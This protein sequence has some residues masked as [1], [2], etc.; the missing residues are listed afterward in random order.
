MPVINRL[1]DFKDEFAALRRELHQNPQ[2]KYEETFAAETIAKTL[3]ALGI[4]F[5]T[6]YGKT[7]IVATIEGQKTDSGKTIGLRADM[8]ALDIIEK[9]GQPWASKTPGKM[10]G[11]GHDGHTS[12]LLATAK[13]LQET[14]NFNGKVHLVFQ[15]A[16]E[17]GR[18][19]NAMMDDGLFRDFKIDSIYGLHNWPYLPLGHVQV[20]SGPMLANVDEFKL[21]INGKGGH[22]AY[23]QGTID[24]LIIGAQ[25]VTALQT[26]VSRNAEPIDPLVV[27]VTN[28]NAGTGAFNVIAD[29]ATISGTVRSF[30]DV[31]R[32]L[33]ERRINEM[34]EGFAKIHGVAIDIDYHYDIDATINT[35]AETVLAAEIAAKV[36]GRE[37]VSTADLCMG[38]EDFG[39]FLTE[40]PGSYIFI[41]QGTKEKDSPHNHGLHS[42]F[43]DFNDDLI[44]LA[45]TYFA[46]LVE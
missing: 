27:S 2:T 37:N 12:I 32:K 42:P 38:G 24:P 16:E 15:P 46:E 6:G 18:G 43:Y 36:V 20:R 23:P 45:A 28:F 10:H 14:R 29:T 33:A 35:E 41:G 7:G 19:A 22:A 5:K 13:Y 34:A 39:S 4:P 44:P 3:G 40:K 9:S 11:C 25:L 1:A 17:G 26:I 21:V 8:D 31:N 30:S